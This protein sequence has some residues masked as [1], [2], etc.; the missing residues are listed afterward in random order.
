MGSQPI[1]MNGQ[2]GDVGSAGDNLK[3]QKCGQQGQPAC[4]GHQQGLAGAV[5]GSIRF[6]LKPDEQIRKN[7]GQFP[8]HEQGHHVVGADQSQHG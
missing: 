8:E 5:P 1:G 7:G 4:A 6:M 2:A 3:Q